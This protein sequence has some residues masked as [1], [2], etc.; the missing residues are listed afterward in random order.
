ME[1][2]KRIRDSI[3][4]ALKKESAKQE[5]RSN[6]IHV[7]DIIQCLRKSYY[8]KKNKHNMLNL[9][10]LRGKSMHDILLKHMA[11]YLN[12]KYEV[13]VKYTID[14]IDIIG[15][16]DILL[17]NGDIIELKTAGYT[18]HSIPSR[19]IYQVQAY[20]NIIR[21]NI[22]YLVIIYNND[23]SIHNIHRDEDFLHIIEDRT[24]DLYYALCSNTIP[25]NRWIYHSDAKYECYNCRYRH[26]CT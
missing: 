4:Y 19:Y 18:M 24:K 3:Q 21:G 2:N 7:S 10:M 13:E 14:N 9:S 1:I 11:E 22:G 8:D 12:A 23:I 15:T 26:K 17:D 5:D 20:L 16:I 25:K 6:S